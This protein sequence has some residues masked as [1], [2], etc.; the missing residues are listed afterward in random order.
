VYLWA[1]TNM[2]QGDTWTFPAPDP[3]VVCIGLTTKRAV[4][5]ESYGAQRSLIVFYPMKH[6][7]TEF[8]TNH[9]ICMV[10]SLH[11]FKC[12][13]FRKTLH[14]VTFGIPVSRD[15]RHVELSELRTKLY[16]SC[17]TVAA[18]IHGRQGDLAW[19][20]EHL[21]STTFLCHE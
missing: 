9:H 7:H 12:K 4:I 17:F 20:T 6:F 11:A 18:E 16:L 13:R 3:A 14:T 21:V 15:A 10:D 2:F 19:R 8:L 1:V 5:T